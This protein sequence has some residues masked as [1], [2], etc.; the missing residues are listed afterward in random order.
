M[1]FVL[2][3]MPCAGKTTLLTAISDKLRIIN[4]S[5]WLNKYSDRKFACLTEKEKVQCRIK[6]TDYLASITDEH[7]ISDGH[8]AFDDTV[9]FTEADGNIYDVFFYLYCEPTEILNRMMVSQKNQ[10]YAAFTVDAI[11][12]WQDFEIEQLRLECHKR[13]KD[14]YVVKSEIITSTDF[15]EFIDAIISGFSSYQLAVNLVEQIRQWYPEPCELSIVDGDKTFINEDSFRLCSHTFP[16]TVFNGDF[17]TGY[18]GYCFERETS[19]ITLDYKQLQNCTINKLVWQNINC[20]NFVVLSAGITQLWERLQH[21][22]NIPHIIA[23]PNISADTKYFIGKLLRNN[24]YYIKV[25]GDSKND[26]YLLKEADEGYLCLGKRISR[27][28]LKADTSMVSLL[29]DVD[30]FILE[31]NEDISKEVAICKSSSAVDGSRLAS[32]HFELGRKLG[33]YIKQKFPNAKTPVMVLERGGRF[34]GDG[35]Y[36]TFG[37]CLYPYNAKSDAIPNIKGNF[38]VIVDSVINTG[39]SMIKLISGLKKNNPNIKVCIATNVI[40]RE[41]LSKLREYTV[42]AVRVSDNK[43]LGKRQKKQIEN[44]GPDTADRLFNL[45]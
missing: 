8:Y 11:E 21:Q 25:Y 7:I 14:F 13:N 9:V 40:Q 4:G 19:D 2:Y 27:S 42:F 36:T 44:I 35:L 18:Q 26:L 37:G 22:F 5:S 45:L 30:K 28:L 10:K 32:V 34:F 20:K 43:F 12:Q 1:K 31:D 33:G 38:A 29:Y 6:Y 23:S 24:G 16:T 3:G 17:Y 39:N 15:S 41:A